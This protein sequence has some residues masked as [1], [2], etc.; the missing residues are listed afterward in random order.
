MCILLHFIGIH[1]VSMAQRYYYYYYY[2]HCDYYHFSSVM[3]SSI[4]N[5]IFFSFWSFCFICSSFCWVF[6]FHS[7]GAQSHKMWKFT[8]ELKWSQIQVWLRQIWKLWCSFLYIYAQPKAS[9]HSLKNIVRCTH[10][11]YAQI[12]IWCERHDNKNDFCSLCRAKIH[13][14]QMINWAHS[15]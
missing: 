3:L 1:D 9:L 6:V 7:N 11:S 14:M 2:Y 4:I 5:R 10:T 13:V 12:V 15:V 8:R